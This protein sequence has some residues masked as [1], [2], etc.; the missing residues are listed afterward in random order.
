MGESA[1]NRAEI[2]QLV[3]RIAR[4]PAYRQELRDH[5]AQALQ[6][7]GLAG[8]TA[9]DDVSGYILPNCTHTCIAGG[10]CGK[11]PTCSTGTCSDVTQPWPL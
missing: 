11:G 2:E 8:A 10:T 9:E 5:P 1:R 4:D 3:D 7:L 6:A